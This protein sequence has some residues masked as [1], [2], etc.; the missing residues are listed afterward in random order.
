[1]L[2]KDRAGLEGVETIAIWLFVGTNG[3]IWLILAF[4]LSSSFLRLA[5]SLINEQ[6][7][8]IQILF[9]IYFLKASS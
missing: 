3:V 5:T 4:K 7:R 1:M 8:E 9:Q 2:T 6:V